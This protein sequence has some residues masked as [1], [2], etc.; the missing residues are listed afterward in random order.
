MQR[1]LS[2]YNNKRMKRSELTPENAEFYNLGLEDAAQLFR[3]P[4]KVPLRKI[5]WYK[6][7]DTNSGFPHFARRTD[8]RD[9]IVDETY[10]LFN[11]IA[12]TKSKKFKDYKVP[13]VRPFLKPMVAPVDKVV[14][15]ATWCYPAVMSCAESVFGTNLYKAILEYRDICELPICLGR[16]MFT[17]VG[18]YLR[19]IRPGE[20]CFIGDYVKGDKNVPS[21]KIRD[22]FKIAGSMIDFDYVGSD[23]ISDRGK[24]AYL[25][26]WEYLQWYFINTPFVF[27]DILYRKEGGFPSGSLFTL[28]IWLIVNVIDR[29]VLT[30]KLEGRRLE[31]GEALAGGDDGA[32]IVKDAS[33]TLDDYVT[34]A[35]EIGTK[36]HRAPKSSLEG[37][38]TLL[39]QPMLSTVFSDVN[40]FVR[41]EV[42]VFGRCCYPSR[43]V[44]SLEEA[45]GRV[46]SL[47][48]S[49]ANTMDRVHAFASY[50]LELPNLRWGMPIQMDPNIWK[51]HRYVTGLKELRDKRTTLAMLCRAWCDRFKWMKIFLR[52]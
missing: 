33:L 34:G 23:K 16:G 17:K 26:N 46:L 19:K 45:I 5:H 44:R 9:Q 40:A 35:A 18:Q 7:E 3:L 38:Q 20:K 14:S 42:D 10:K 22:A 6:P 4:H 51:Y 8:I 32:N 31:R 49:T 39:E 43:W 36:F 24:E 13:P 29:A 37:P 41:D 25:R 50:L 30:R 47:S 52:M 2:L 28:L 1:E 27:D 15:R 21:W 12:A 48:M 11:H